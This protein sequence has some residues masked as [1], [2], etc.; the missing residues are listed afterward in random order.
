[1]GLRLQRLLL[2]VG[3]FIF[4]QTRSLGFGVW[5]LGFRVW[6]LGLGV[7]GYCF[8]FARTR[9]SDDGSSDGP[10]RRDRVRHSK[11]GGLRQ[12]RHK[13]VIFEGARPLKTGDFCPF[14]DE[15]PS[16][17]QSYK[18]EPIR[19]VRCPRKRKTLKGL[20]YF[21]LK[22]GPDSGPD[23]ITGVPRSLESPSPVGVYSRPMPRDLR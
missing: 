14:C 6:G 2:R 4:H 15:L 12:K 16:L 13:P 20:S 19:W 1:M 5:S 10:V 17:S 7:E 3:R 18:L 21:T 8:L 22:P 11:T 9:S 23:C